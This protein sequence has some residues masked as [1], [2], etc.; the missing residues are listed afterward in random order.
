MERRKVNWKSFINSKDKTQMLTALHPVCLHPSLPV[1][2]INPMMGQTLR[3]SRGVPTHQDSPF[4]I[5]P[6]G[7]GKRCAVG[8][9]TK[10]VSVRWSLI[11]VFSSPAVTP[12]IARLWRLRWRHRRRRQTR[13]FLKRFPL[14]PIQRTWRRRGDPDCLFEALIALSPVVDSDIFPLLDACM[15]WIF[16]PSL[17]YFLRLFLYTVSFVLFL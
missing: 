9:S 12:R 6:I 8:L 15:S 11:L 2:V 13:R 3:P 1:T 17:L 14:L 10:G 5:C 16:F 7:K 4:L